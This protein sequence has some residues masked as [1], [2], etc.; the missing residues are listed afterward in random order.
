CARLDRAYPDAPAELGLRDVQHALAREHGVPGWRALKDALADFAL[1]NRAHAERVASFLQMACLDWRVGGPQR[2]IHLFAAGRILKRHPEIAGDGIYTAVV[3]G[4]GEE[5]E[6][7]LAERPQAASE[8]GGPRGWPPL[9]YLCNARLP[10]AADGD[11]AVAVARALL[12]RGAD[13]N[14]Y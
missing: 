10:L 13:P 9:L 3:C 2:A 6:R 12:D 4:E 8:P 11:N 5:V 7:I 1:V 14:A